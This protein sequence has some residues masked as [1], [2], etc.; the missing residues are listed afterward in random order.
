MILIETHGLKREIQLLN[1]RC[2][3]DGKGKL[4]RFLDENEPEHE[5]VGTR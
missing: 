3:F 4:G 5:L 2:V 1:Y